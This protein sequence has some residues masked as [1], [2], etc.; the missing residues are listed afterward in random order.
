[1]RMHVRQVVLNKTRRFVGQISCL[2]LAVLCLSAE[3]GWSQPKTPIATEPGLQTTIKVTG[4]DK[5]GAADVIITPNVWL[6]VPAGKSPTPFLPGGSFTADWEGFVTADLRGDYNFQAELNGA[7]KLE[8]NGAI[9]LETT[10]TG[11]A[12]EPGKTI[13]LNRGRNALKAHFTSPA[14]GDAFVRLLWKPADS[15][16]QP[17]PL[18]ALSRAADAPEFKQAAKIHLGRELFLDSR[19]AKCHAGPAPDAAVPE[20]SMDAPSFEDIGSRRNYDW[21]ARWIQDPKALRPTAHMPKVL[22]GPDAKAGAESIA[23]YLASLK[24]AA[25]NALPSEPTPDQADAGKKLFTALHCEACHNAPDATETD[26]AKIFLKQVRQKFAPGSLVAF[27]QKPE[28]HYSWIRMP[29][30]KLSPDEATRL[31]AYLNSTA[32]KAGEGT[33]STDTAIIEHGKKLVQTSGCLNCHTLKLD[34][35]FSTH[36]LAE[37]SPDHWKQGCLAST[38]DDTSKALHFSFTAD[39]REALQAFAATDRVSLARH[40]PAD[41]AERQTRALN[42]RECHGKFEGFPAFDILGGKLKPEWSKAFIAGEIAY[43]PRPWLEARMPAFTSRAELIAQGLATQHG[44][45]PQTPAEPPIDL[46]AAQVGQKLISAV[47]GFSCVSCHAVGDVAATQVFESAGLNFAHSG[48][49]LLN[50]YVHRWVR[51]PQL[52]E[53]TT[54]M[55]FYFDGGKSQL[56]NILDGDPTNQI[57]AIWQYLRQGEKMP[58][59]VRQ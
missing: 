27:L 7:L 46:E 4:T 15:F 35:Q 44:F 10:G 24:S 43:K 6:Y 14:Q 1:M 12:T 11:I 37:L 18:P 50:S 59:P 23:A 26:P 16:F 8:I 38:P 36:S 9:A 29:N 13:R 39:E 56:V 17:I 52:I 33:A 3:T 20:L 2:V 49:R 21:M 34:N 51:N 55:P 5:P 45:A 47:G 25:P 53:P 54:K 31:A 48:D 22:H 32:D 19:C 58:Q 57:N 41:F 30:F 28:A 40:V 42:C